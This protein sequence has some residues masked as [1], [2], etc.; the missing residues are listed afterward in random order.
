MV[1]WKADLLSQIV[2]QD[3]NE[4][5]IAILVEEGFVREFGVLVAQAG[6]CL[7]VDD[8]AVVVDGEVEV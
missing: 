8:A 5:A 7:G 4:L 1:A 2:G 3:V 6:R